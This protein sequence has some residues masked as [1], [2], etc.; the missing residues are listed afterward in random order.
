MKAQSR[1]SK[2]YSENFD[3]IFK[4][5][6]TKEYSRVKII[7]PVKQSRF[8]QLETAKISKLFHDAFPGL[9]KVKSKRKQK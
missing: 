6:A 8:P 2:I 7:K 5:K 4:S 3:K 9:Q 1:H